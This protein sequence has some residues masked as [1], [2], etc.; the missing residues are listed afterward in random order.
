[1]IRAV[2]DPQRYPIGHHL[3]YGGHVA[4][5]LDHN[6]WAI[7][8]AALS[9]DARLLSPGLI[10][11][12]GRDSRFEVLADL[13]Y[14]QVRD[15]ATGVLLLFLPGGYAVPQSEHD[16]FWDS[17]PDPVKASVEAHVL[18]RLTTPPREGA[19][20]VH[21]LVRSTPADKE[22][23]VVIDGGSTQ[24][25]AALRLREGSY[26]AISGRVAFRPELDGP[27]IVGNLEY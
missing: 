14:Y 17:L 22:Y 11:D 2:S 13:E 20:G 9:T 23:E 6:V 7:S 26:A 4:E 5:K 3:H 25:A 19:D 16:G 10:R 1:M 8:G 24:K 15:H 18:G 21:F 12:D 27:L